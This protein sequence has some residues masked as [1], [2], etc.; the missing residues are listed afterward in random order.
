MQQEGRVFKHPLDD[1]LSDEIARLRKEVK[2]SP[3]GVGHD[4]LLRRAGQAETAARTSELLNS[5]GL[6]APT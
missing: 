4:N 2:N 6:K 5:P 3:P 1:R